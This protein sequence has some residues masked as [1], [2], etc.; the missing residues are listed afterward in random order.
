MDSR[1]DFLFMKT[2]QRLWRS[3]LFLTLL[4]ALCASS[5]LPFVNMAANAA[6][7][8]QA[9]TNVVISEFRTR[10]SAGG[11]DEFVEIFNPTANPVDIGGWLIRASNNAGNTGVRYTFPV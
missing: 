1:W 2:S 7:Q 10:G 4:A 9:A 3:L 11:N 6:P 8:M 5:V